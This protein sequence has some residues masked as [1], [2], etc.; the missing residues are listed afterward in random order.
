MRDFGTAQF[1]KLLLL[2]TCAMGAEFFLA[3]AD[4]VIAGHLIGESALAGIN[5]LAPVLNL[6]QFTASLLATGCSMRFSFETGRYDRRRASEMFSQGLLAV[7][8]AGGV[9]LALFLLGRE[10][11]LAA[12]G[13]EASVSDF[14]RSYWV[15]YAPC[16]VL[17]PLTV[18]LLALV[19]SDGD[20]RACAFA[21]VSLVGGNIVCSYFLCR[22]MG[23]AGCAL[24]TV[25]GNFA[26]ILSL[27]SHFLTKGNT[28][29]LVRHWSWRDLYEICR[30]SFADAS[31]TLCWALLFFLLAKLVIVEFGSGLL[32]VLSIV[33]ACVNLTI[34]YNG[35]AAA[36]QP[37]VSIYAGERNGRA[38]RKVMHVALAVAA[39]EG[40]ACAVFFAV[41]PSAAVALVGISDPAL[42]PIAEKAVRIVAIGFIGAPFVFLFN[43]YYLFI[44]RYAL[45]YAVTFAADIVVYAVLCPPLAHFG[46]PTGL[47]IALGL[48]PVIAVAAFA[49]YV[50]CRYGRDRFPFLLPREREANQ[51]AIGF[52]V[53]AAEIAAAADA[54][55][56]AV[57]SRMGNEAAA[58]AAEIVGKVFAAVA[59]TNAGKTVLGEAGLDFNDGAARLVLRDDGELK[60]NTAAA[61]P[62][63][64]EYFVTM[65]YNRGVFDLLNDNGKERK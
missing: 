65:G 47:W 40:L 31:V 26:A 48:A 42:V 39:A 45:A 15:W 17:L 20:L 16:T 57:A 2:A 19:Y 64:G 50:R 18:F 24:G 55:R 30:S 28:M 43:S 14:A 41:M 49:L 56:V 59:E 5:L 46:G 63:F 58:R 61:A 8:A 12:L 9:L 53:R 62:A 10:T 23:I 44:E 6:V 25:L 29:R 36:A 27:S 3:L 4:T 22:R 13:A 38:I 7:L 1:R 35:V 11:F 21:Y 37:I 60:D 54:T 52:R 33:L 51:S 32:P 34:L